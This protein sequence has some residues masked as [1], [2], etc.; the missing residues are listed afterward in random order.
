MYFVWHLS[1]TC[2]TNT[3]IL[4]ISLA[5]PIKLDPLWKFRL[6][7]MSRLSRFYDVVDGDWA[8]ADIKEEGNEIKVFPIPKRPQTWVV[9]MFAVGKELGLGLLQEKIQVSQCVVELVTK[10]R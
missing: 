2:I 9:S 10:F 6:N 4:V 1:C 5:G 7:R 8:W 3:L